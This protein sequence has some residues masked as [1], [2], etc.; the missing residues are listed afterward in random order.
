MK[1]P[2]ISAF[3]EWLEARVDPFPDAQ[4]SKPPTE[5][6]PFIRHY[7]WPFRHL[8]LVTVI[9]STL[10]AALEVY[11]FARVGDVIDWVGASAP[12]TFFETYGVELLLLSALVLLLLPALNFSTLR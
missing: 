8:V 4:P 10:V 12:G 9:L 5:F 7:A 2:G 6:W 3:F 1:L 11:V